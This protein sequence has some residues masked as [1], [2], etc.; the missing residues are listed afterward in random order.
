MSAGIFAVAATACGGASR[1]DGATVATSTPVASAPTDIPGAAARATLHGALTLDGAPVEAEFLGVRVIRD[2][3]SAACQ[4]TIP[5]VF[6]RYYEVKVVA[7][8]EVRGC[9]APGG[10]LLLWVYTDDTFLYSQETLPWP[11]NGATA[12]FDATFSSDAP[13]G[14]SLPATEFKGHLFDRHGGRLPGGTVVEAF[15]GDVRCGV[16]S[17]RYGDVTEGYYTLI[18]AGPESVPGCTE[19]ATLSFRL[20]GAPA[21]ETAINDLA[22]GGENRPDLDLTL[23]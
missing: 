10:E 9:G 12:T 5:A 6:Q 20:S 21:V 16:T 11:G 7:D 15:V 4:D 19:G 17:L 2:G 8:A 23:Q 13:A 14:A 22:G 3:L 18:V 1:D